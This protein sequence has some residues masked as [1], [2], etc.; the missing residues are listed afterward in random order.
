MAVAKKTY[1]GI[2]VS[3][4]SALSN[5]KFTARITKP[6]HANKWV[7]IFM[8]SLCIWQQLFKSKF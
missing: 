1:M 8:V 2:F 6:M 4:D 7:H 3:P 5:I